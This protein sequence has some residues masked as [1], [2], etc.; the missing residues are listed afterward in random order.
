MPPLSE[1]VPLGGYS[2]VRPQIGFTSS[3]TDSL[4]AC[5]SKMQKWA[6]NEKAKADQVAESY[7]QSLLQEQASIDSQM[8]TLLAVQLERG[9][10]VD[11]QQN[12][13]DNQIESSISTRKQ[14]LEEQR[15]VLEVEISKLQTEYQ[16]REKR[17][18]GESNDTRK[19][20]DYLISTNQA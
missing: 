10:N 7:R 15:K 2:T 17:V 6:E 13:S 14:V 9:L 4:V 1:H 8:T 3:L 20:F 11:Q 12:S 19:C 16:N 18:R 5:R